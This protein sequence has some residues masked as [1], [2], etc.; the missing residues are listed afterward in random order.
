[1]SVYT[2]FFTETYGDYGL[3]GVYSTKAKAEQGIEEAMKLYHGSDYEE[4]KWDREI[5]DGYERI[6]DEYLVIES[7][8]DKEAHI[9]L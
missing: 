6:E 8:L 1:M 3:V 9:L 7:D 2:V 4:T 5:S